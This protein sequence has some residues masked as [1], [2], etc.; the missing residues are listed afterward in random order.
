MLTY[1]DLT[2][3]QLDVLQAANQRYMNFLAF[4]GEAYLDEQARPDRAAYPHLLTKSP[5]G[6]PCV[7]DEKSVDFLV[8]VTGQPREVCFVYSDA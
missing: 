3:K 2:E 7:S 4:D 1:D 5:A 6:N 8:A